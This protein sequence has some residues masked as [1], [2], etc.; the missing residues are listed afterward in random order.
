MGS[1]RPS[2]S[3]QTPA[4]ALEPALALALE[5]PQ[6]HAAVS[7][8]LS[9]LDER[10]RRMITARFG[11]A[12]NQP[13]TLQKIGT[14]ENITRERV[15]QLERAALNTLRNSELVVSEGARAVRGSLRAA[16]DYMGRVAREDVLIASLHLAEAKDSSALRFLL[17]TLPGVTEARE[18]QRTHAHWTVTDEPSDAPPVILLEH[19]LE[20]AEDILRR[21]KE[22]L[23]NDIFLSE[24][25][26]GLKSPGSGE[27]VSGTALHSLLSTSKRIARTPFG[28]WGLRE[29]PEVLPRGV[30]DKAYIV[31]KRSGKPL[32]FRA[33]TEEV[34]AAGFSKKRA[35]AQTV[36]NEL[37]RDDRFALVGRGLYGLREW[38]YVPGTVAEVAARLLARAGR[39]LKKRDLVIAVLKE[40]LVKRNTVLLA[41]QNKSLFRVLDDGAYVLA[42]PEPRSGSA[43]NGDPGGAPPPD[44]SAPPTA[45]KALQ[46]RPATP[47]PP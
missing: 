38:G 14:A 25:S 39:P 13:R 26:K 16:L 17:A 36:H 45:H 37:I 46:S 8:L 3:P 40:R 41:L 10:T 30:G 34:N 23:A 15:R 7:E 11:L 6:L 35:H 22:V 31:L 28:E 21:T 19:V 12:D 43:V 20:V 27:P 18:T 42:V 47:P 33:L 2:N 1:S 4:L 44:G 29:W 5:A 9:V 24:V 32:H